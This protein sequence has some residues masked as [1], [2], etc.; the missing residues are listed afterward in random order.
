MRT[1]TKHIFAKLDVTSRAAAVRRAE[2][3]GLI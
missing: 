3:L 1:H 2:A